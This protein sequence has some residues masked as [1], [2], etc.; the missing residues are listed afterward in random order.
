MEYHTFDADRADKLE[1]AQ[2]RYRFLSAEELLWALSSDGDE[3]VADFGSGTGFYTDDVA[4]AVDQAYAV[5]IQ[6]AMHDYYRE[7]G[8]PD[9]VELVTSGVDDL[10]LDTNSLDAAFPTM[11]YHEFAGEEALDEITRV[12][13]DAD[14]LIIVDW[15]ATGSGDHGP[16]LDER[17]RAAE[18]ANDLREAGFHIEHTAVR[19]ETFLLIGELRQETTPVFEGLLGRTAESV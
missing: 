4:P 10:L 18:M 8:V 2:Q 12:L 6:E 13:T 11:T 15:A 17:F 14:R 16:P 19:P 3:T 1:D 7:K 5:D 9:N